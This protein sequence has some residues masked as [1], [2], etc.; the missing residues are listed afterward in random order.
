MDTCKTR[1]LRQWI[2]HSLE[3]IVTVV[4]NI[5]FGW[6][7]PEKNIILNINQ[8]RRLMSI[9][10]LF[11]DAIKKKYGTELTKISNICSTRLLTDHYCHSIRT[12]SNI[13]TKA[14]D[15]ILLWR[16]IVG[17][18]KHV[19][20]RYDICWIRIGHAHKF[21]QWA[22]LLIVTESFP[23]LEHPPG[24][25]VHLDGVHIFGLELVQAS[26]TFGFICSRQAFLQNNIQINT[27]YTNLLFWI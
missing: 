21:K 20:R 18:R 5:G 10:I 22:W 19:T 26:I 4:K 14:D 11:V 2:P 17:N 16:H 6:S 1:D 7:H 9:A 15:T 3:I 27:L 8:Y 13:L 23:A 12:G 25:G 24:S